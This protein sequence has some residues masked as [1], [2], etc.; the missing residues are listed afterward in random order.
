MQVLTVVKKTQQYASRK[1][2][3]RIFGYADP[4]RLLK[5]FRDYA[6]ADKDV[7][8]PR[9]PYIKQ[10]GMDTIYDIVC[11]AYFIEN[12]DLLEAGTRSV[13]FKEELPRLR[14]AYRE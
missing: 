2:I 4:T 3:G 6:D 5:A 11:F 14:E 1:D 7:F 13:S 10:S 9:K 12:K 8:F